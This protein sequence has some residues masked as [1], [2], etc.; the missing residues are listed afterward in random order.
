MPKESTIAVS[1]STLKLVKDYQEEINAK[2]LEE[3][4]K[5]AIGWGKT[6]NRF[7]LVP[8]VEL[9]NR[10]TKL[11]NITMNLLSIVLTLDSKI[12][13]LENKEKVN[14]NE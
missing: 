3:T 1:K 8:Q 9:D 5:L 2:S 10:L 13:K 4:V 7:G 6:Y 14:E 11:E 12:K